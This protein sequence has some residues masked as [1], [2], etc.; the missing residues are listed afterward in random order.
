MIKKFVR[1]PSI[2]AFGKQTPAQFE[3]LMESIRLETQKLVDTV[4]ENAD[5]EA[6]ANELKQTVDRLGNLM[7][8]VVN[9]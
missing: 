2:H 8:S 1:Y 5:K 7:E 4:T 9:Q 6:E 3:F